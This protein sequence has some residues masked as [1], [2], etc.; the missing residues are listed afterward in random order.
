MGDPSDCLTVDGPDRL[1]LVRVTEGKDRQGTFHFGTLPSR[2]DYAVRCLDWLAPRRNGAPLLGGQ[3]RR[4]HEWRN[5]D[6]WNSAVVTP[7]VAMRDRWQQIVDWLTAQRM[8][9]ATQAA[10]L[11]ASFHIEVSDGRVDRTLPL[12]EIK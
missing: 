9:D 3:E 11:R 12:P 7:M 6:T 8:V 2:A 5:V 4:R 10:T 1:F